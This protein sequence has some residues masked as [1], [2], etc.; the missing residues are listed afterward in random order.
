MNTESRNGIAEVEPLQMRC[1]PAPLAGGQTLIVGV[2]L[3][4]RG[5]SSVCCW[6]CERTIDA[7][8]LI[9]TEPQGL[10]RAGDHQLDRRVGILLCKN[11][12]SE[13]AR[14]GIDFCYKAKP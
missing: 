7:G 4:V 3:V 11:C 10:T 2:N 8:K 1:Q 13:L 14:I 6:S 9:V 12:Q 5:A